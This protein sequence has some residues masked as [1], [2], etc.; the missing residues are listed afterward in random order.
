MLPVYQYIYLNVLFR[1]QVT[2]TWKWSI[3]ISKLVIIILNCLR[4]NYSNTEGGGGGIYNFL[5]PA[6]LLWL[7]LLIVTFFSGH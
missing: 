1:N 6:V 4:N 5:L 3:S 2:M 7:L